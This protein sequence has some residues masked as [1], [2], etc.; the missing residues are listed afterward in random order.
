MEKQSH[1]KF[2]IKYILLSILFMIL[3]IFTALNISIPLTAYADTTT[4]IGQT[5]NLD[6]YSANEDDESTN[7][8]AGYLYWAASSKRCGVLFYVVDEKGVIQT[9]GLV[10]D[11]AGVGEFGRYT[12]AA[13]GSVKGITGKDALDYQQILIQYQMTS[14]QVRVTNLQIDSQ[15]RLVDKQETTSNQHPNL[16]SQSRN[17]KIAPM[18]GQTQAFWSADKRNGREAV[19]NR[20]A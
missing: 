15:G 9:H 1:N 17:P 4:N 11:K 18:H 5:M 14:N 8:Q 20:T 7:E 16:Q 3:F 12:N 10:M 19:E 6:S 2:K 13:L